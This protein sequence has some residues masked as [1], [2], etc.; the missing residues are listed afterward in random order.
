[1]PVVLQALEEL[2]ISGEDLA[3]IALTHI[4]L[5]HAGGVGDLAKAFPTAT[6]YV[7]ELGARH[8]VDPTRLVAS[9][10]RV[11]GDRLDLLYGRLEPTEAS[12][13]VVV[14]EG[15]RIAVGERELEVINSPG[16]AKHHLGFVDSVSGILFCGDAVGVRLPDIGVLR[17]ATPPPDFDLDAMLGSL[18]RFA[19][20][21]PSSIALA[22]Y[23]VVPGEPADVLAEAGETVRSWAGIAA[24][25]YRSGRSIETDLQAAFGSDLSNFDEEARR[26]AETLNGIHSNAAGFRRWLETSSPEDAPER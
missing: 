23:G 10:E 7:H 5:D 15:E 17:P 4:H 26:R 9:A 18:T 21:A 14:G 1:V 6:V 20:R 2:G 19:E 11:Y 8:L 3:G 22:H 25:A 24:A 16:H 12:R 13:V